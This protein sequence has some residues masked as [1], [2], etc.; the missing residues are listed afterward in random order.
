[1]SSERNASNLSAGGERYASPPEDTR[2][3]APEN[4]SSQTSNSDPVSELMDAVLRETIGVMTDDEAYIIIQRW[5]REQGADLHLD[6]QTCH[7]LVGYI[8]KERFRGWEIPT[9]HVSRIA[10]R[11]WDDPV[12]RER[13]GVLWDEASK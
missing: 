7:S 13:L 5:F 12:A 2:G 3:N 4:G 11:L 10:D 8:L 6:R 9:T 1:M